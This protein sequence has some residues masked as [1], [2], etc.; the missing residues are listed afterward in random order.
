ML[1]KIEI[2]EKARALGFD[3]IG[4]TTA[5]PFKS[6][7]EVLDKRKEAYNHYI[8]EVTAAAH[9]IGIVVDVADWSEY[10]DGMLQ[11]FIDEMS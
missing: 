2:I 1:N 6:Q 3:E 4:F 8:N 7:R 9:G 5:E 11:K 10:A